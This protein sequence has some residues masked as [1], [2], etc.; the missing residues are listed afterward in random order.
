MKKV[1]L[2][3]AIALLSAC[4][5]KTEFGDCVGA[6]DEKKPE[7]TY[8]LSGW[9]T[10]VGVVFSELFLVPPIMVLVNETFCPVAK[11]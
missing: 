4:T 8:K 9:N 6:F 5:S 10:F 7:L 2:V 3:A 11:K 1:I